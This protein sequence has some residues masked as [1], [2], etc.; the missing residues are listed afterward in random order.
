MAAPGNPSTRAEPGSPGVAAMAAAL[1]AGRLAIGAGLMFAPGRTLEALGFE[2][3]SETTVAVARLA[4]IRDLVL[5]AAQGLAIGDRDRLRRSSLA[6]AAADAGDAAVF[7]S[8]LGARRPARRAG[9][10][11]AAAAAPAALAGLWLASRLG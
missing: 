6:C 1:A 11:G 7:A 2:A 10:R 5:G 8:L 3:P 9:M 4:G